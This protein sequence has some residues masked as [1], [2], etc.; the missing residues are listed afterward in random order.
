MRLKSI[1]EKIIESILMASSA[2][3]SVTVLLIV[4]FLFKEGLGLFSQTPVEKGFSLV[5]NKNN[6]VNTLSANQIRLIFDQEITNWKAVGG[7]DTDIVLFRIDD[8]TSYYTEEEIG[9]NFEHLADKVDELVSQHPE[10]ISF[11]ADK[12]IPK[13]AHIKKLNI[14][15]IDFAE[16]FKNKDWMPTAT[17]AAQ[18]GVLPLLIGTLLVSLG[19]ILLALP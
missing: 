4:F 1:I 15:K 13:N 17:P 18:L 19:A 3:T 6:P 5:V 14:P 2:I 12:Y 9:A 16:L 8:I 10:M 7:A 11:V